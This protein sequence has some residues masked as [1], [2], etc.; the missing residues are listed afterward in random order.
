MLLPTKDG[1]DKWNTTRSIHQGRHLGSVT[2]D[3]EAKMKEIEKLGEQKGWSTEKY[4]TELKELIQEERSIL[5]SGQRA[6]N[7][8]QRPWANK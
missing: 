4:A 5:R 6:L 2:K 1:A 3:L 7:K 8:N